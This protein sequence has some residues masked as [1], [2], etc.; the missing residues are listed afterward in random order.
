M[1][2]AGN[3]NTLRGDL[4]VALQCGAFAALMG[5]LCYAATPL[6]SRA[7]P[8]APRLASVRFDRDLAARLQLPPH[9]RVAA[10]VED[11][12]TVSF[13]VAGAAGRIGAAEAGCRARAPGPCLAK[14][15]CVSLAPRTVRPGDTIVL[16]VDP[17]RADDPGRDGA[18]ATTLLRVH[19]APVRPPA[20]ARGT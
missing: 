15:N 9:N 10:N 8:H 7:L 3:R 11:G 2:P 5:G 17:G 16:C 12:V 4:L 20:G 13:R 6:W 1:H 19:P 18:R 14:I